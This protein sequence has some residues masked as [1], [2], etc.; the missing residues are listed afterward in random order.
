MA[1]A[2]CKRR[3]GAAGAEMRGVSTLFGISLFLQ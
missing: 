3:K 2:A 1:P